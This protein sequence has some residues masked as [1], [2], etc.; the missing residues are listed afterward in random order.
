M[1]AEI[2]I[3]VVDLAADEEAYESMSV[4]LREEI[5]S[6]DVND[7]RFV[8]TGP[9][10]DGTRGPDVTMVNQLLVTMPASLA[11]VAALVNTV[12]GWLSRSSDGRTVELTLGDKSLKLARASSD[13]QQR[14]IEEFLQSAQHAQ[15]DSG[16]DS[17]P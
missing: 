12:R 4:A 5:L 2:R 14:L 6:T 13:E 17:E 8:Q 3:T 15:P 1:G 9:A 10:P 16:G 7:V 11:A